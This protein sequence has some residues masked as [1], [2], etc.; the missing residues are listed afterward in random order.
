M[1]DKL[2]T[3]AIRTYQRAQMIKTVLEENGI[4]TIIHNLNLENPEM[5]VGVRVRIKESDLPRA[6][7]IVEKIESEWENDKEKKEKQQ[8]LIPIDF[9]DH[10]ANA[11]DFGFDFAKKHDAEVTFLYVYYS[12]TYTILSNKDRITYS[13]SDGEML[14][15][16]V[17]AANADVENM[18]NLLDRRIRDGELPKIPFSFE[19]KEGVPEEEILDYCK[20]YNPALVVMGTRGKKISKNN[21]L[22]G[23]VTA[24]VIDSCPSP[25]FALPIE[26]HLK[27]PNDIDRVAFLTNFDQKDLIAIDNLIGLLG[28]E[29]LRIHFIHTTEKDEVWDEIMLSGIKTY[30]STHYPRLTTRYE[31]IKGDLSNTEVLDDYLAKQKIDVLAFNARRRNLFARLFN[32]GLA[33]KMVLH[34][35]TPL[36][37]S[38]E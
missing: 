34:S 16:I 30:F 21:E 24:E 6:L 38:R 26:T 29:N 5:A 1:A 9:S 32:P 14:R 22:I 19:L 17:T 7:A 28:K 27:A 37:V 33:Y 11:I 8:I 23:S 31:I 3:L 2:V 20:K 12:P 18:T 35:D 36:F 13:I 15:R 4:E 25:V 10:A